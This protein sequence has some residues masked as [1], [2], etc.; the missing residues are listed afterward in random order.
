M[1]VLSTCLR[2]SLCFSVT[3][4]T[5]RRQGSDYTALCVYVIYTT[6][7][8]IGAFNVVHFEDNSLA[9]DRAHRETVGLGNY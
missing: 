7:M 8:N 5:R 9:S 2:R 4:H 6:E 1:N 3:S